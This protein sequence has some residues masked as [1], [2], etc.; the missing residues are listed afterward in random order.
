[1]A[2]Q[3]KTAKDQN[4]S[5]GLLKGSVFTGGAAHVSRSV[6]VIRTTSF[7]VVVDT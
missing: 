4:T 1:M 5:S 3:P 6:S 7:I 2:L